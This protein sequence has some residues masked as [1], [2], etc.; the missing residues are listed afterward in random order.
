MKKQLLQYDEA[1]EDRF[2]KRI[3]AAPELLEAV[4][5]ELTAQKVDHKLKLSDLKDGNFVTIFEDYQKKKMQQ[6]IPEADFEQWLIL[7]NIDTDKLTEL[8]TRYKKLLDIKHYFYSQNHSYWESKE[9]YNKGFDK[10]SHPEAPKKKEYN[11]DD[12]LK[13]SKDSYKLNIDSELFKLYLTNE[14]QAEAMEVVTDQVKLCKRKNDKPADTIRVAGELVKDIDADYN[15][16]WN[17][18][19]I[20]NIK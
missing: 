10:I 14:K 12:F 8:E 16:T 9:T 6:R 17:Y 15:I 5:S 1:Y 20:L 2:I 19:A 18:N 4:K 11:L 3:Q 13:I 7:C